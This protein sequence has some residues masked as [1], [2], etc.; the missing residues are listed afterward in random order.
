LPGFFMPKKRGQITL[1]SRRGTVPLF[2]NKRTEKDSPHFSILKMVQT[3]GSM[4]S[5]KGN[6]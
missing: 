3:T 5:R 1:S 4:G 6:L 2:L